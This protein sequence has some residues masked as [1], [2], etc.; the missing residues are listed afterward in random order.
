VQR[1][2]G[3]ISCWYKAKDGGM[4]SVLIIIAFIVLAPLMELHPYLISIWLLNFT[5]KYLSQIVYNRFN[6]CYSLVC[7][8]SND[9]M[10]KL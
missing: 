5:Q 9:P 10:M 7:L 8:Y 1:I 3:T 2:I 6:D 4:P